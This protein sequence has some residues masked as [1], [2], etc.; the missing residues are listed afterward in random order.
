MVRLQAVLV[1][2][3]TLL[4][5]KAPMRPP[6]AGNAD[7]PENQAI[8]GKLQGYMECLHAHSARN[9]QIADLY[10][11]RLGSNAPTAETGAAVQVSN[12]PKDCV[13]AIKVARPMEPSMREL[14]TAGDAFATAAA[15]VFE[16]TTAAHAHWTRSSKDY[17][18][19]KGIALH[20]KLVAAFGAFDIAQGALFDQVTR[21]NLAVR[22]DQ[23]ARREQREGRTLVIL[24]DEMMIHG[25][26]LVRFASTPWDRLDT[27]GLPAF[28]AKLTAIEDVVAEMTTLALANPQ[29]TESTVAGFAILSDRAQTYLIAARQLL[30]RARDHVTYSDAEKIMIGASNEVSVVGTPAAMIASYNNL[31]A[32]YVAR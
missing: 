29:E 7:T 25:E 8:L 18:P 9:F 21:A 11:A 2:A 5:C 28:T 17:D 27:I 4:G 16:L 19:A 3:I 20:P 10:R 23:R 22:K 13:E 26:E 15:E 31:V 12:D 24:V 14:E 32:V 1:L 6:S 30:Q